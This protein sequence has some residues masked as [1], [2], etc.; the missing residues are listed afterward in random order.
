MKLKALVVDDDEIILKLLEAVVRNFGFDVTT[1]GNGAIAAKALS[2]QGF[3]LVITDLEMGN[4]NGFEVIQLV[5]SINSN[6]I[7]LV[8]SG[9]LDERCRHQAIALGASDYL[10]KPFSVE[11]L[12]KCI[13]SKISNQRS[14]SI[15]FGRRN[16]NVGV[17]K[18]YIM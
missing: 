2:S 17:R 1:A 8:A 15:T 5:K 12:K 3:D 16:R 11:D 14:S 9:C 13:N 4:T 10:L 18:F 6:T 7:V